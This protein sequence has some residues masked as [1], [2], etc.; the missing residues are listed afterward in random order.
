[1]SIRDLYEASDAVGLA[2]LVSRREVTPGELLDEA[3]ER[4]EALN[5]QLNAVTMIQEAVG[6]P[7]HHRRFA[8]W[9]VEGRTFPAEGPWR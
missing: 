5:P 2:Q 4:V 7:S 9:S 1:M 6:A 8:G 3:M